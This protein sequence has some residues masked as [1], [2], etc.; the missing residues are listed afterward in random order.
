MLFRSTANITEDLRATDGNNWI[1]AN[2]LR[3][4]ASDSKNNAYVVGL[5]GVFG[6]Y[7]RSTDIPSDNSNVT[8]GGCGN[9]TALV[10]TGSNNITVA[11]NMTDGSKYTS[12]VWFT[13]DSCTGLAG[14]DWT[15]EASNNCL[16]EGKNFNVNYMYI[17]GNSGRFTVRNSNISATGCSVMP[18]P[19]K[20][21][22]VYA[23]AP[24]ARWNNGC[25]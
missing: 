14:Q 18:N 25:V 15:I 2:N 16:I 13:V 23:E 8:I 7:N 22:G 4:V 9:T 20:I 11:A 1:G 12:I 5:A 21:V 6:Y 17:Q 10:N 24:A 3:S 19:G